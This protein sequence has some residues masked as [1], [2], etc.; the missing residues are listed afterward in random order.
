MDSRIRTLNDG[1]AGERDGKVK[2][3]LQMCDAE[4]LWR[5]VAALNAHLKRKQNNEHQ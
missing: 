3:P 4:E 2:K 5:I 1:I